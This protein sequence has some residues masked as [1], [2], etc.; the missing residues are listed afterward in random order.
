MRMNPGCLFRPP[1]PL[2]GYS[3]T[4]ICLLALGL[5]LCLNKRKPKD[6]MRSCIDKE[7]TLFCK[8]LSCAQILA[9]MKMKKSQLPI[10]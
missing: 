7:G 5:H 4:G 2:T 3:H 10:E 9:N 6:A 1:Q 8:V